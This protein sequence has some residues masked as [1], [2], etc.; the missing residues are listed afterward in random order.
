MT[1]AFCLPSSSSQCSSPTNEDLDP[2]ANGPTTIAVIWPSPEWAY[3]SPQSVSWVAF[4]PEEQLCLEKDN[5]TGNTQRVMVIDGVPCA[6]YASQK[7]L[8]HPQH[9]VLPI[10]RQEKGHERGSLPLVAWATRNPILQ[11]WEYF[12]A[13]VS[14]QVEEVFQ[15][16]ESEVNVAVLNQLWFTI[17]FNHMV[18][19]NEQSQFREVR[20]FEMQPVWEFFDSRKPGWLSFSKKMTDILEDRCTKGVAELELVIQ[21]QKMVVDFKRMRCRQSNGEYLA[22]RHTTIEAEWE[23]E[24]ADHKPM[25]APSPADLQHHTVQLQKTKMRLAPKILDFSSGLADQPL[26]PLLPSPSNAA[27]EN[28]AVPFNVFGRRSSMEAHMSFNRSAL[29]SKRRADRSRSE[30]YPRQGSGSGSS[31]SNWVKPE[32]LLRPPRDNHSPV[33]DVLLHDLGVRR[34]MSA[35]ESH[36]DDSFRLK[37]RN[38]RGRLLQP[39]SS[40]PLSPSSPTAEP[41]GLSPASD[42]SSKPRGIKSNSVPSSL[43][44]DSGR[45]RTTAAS[46]DRHSPRSWSQPPEVSLAPSNNRLRAPAT[47]S[48][49]RQRSLPDGKSTVG[50]VRR[51]P[52]SSLGEDSP[53]SQA[54]S[55]VGPR[56]RVDN[57]NPGYAPG[58]GDVRI[59]KERLRFRENARPRVDDLNL[60]YEPGGGRVRIFSEKLDFRRRA[61]ARVDDDNLDHEPGGGL[62]RIVSEKVDFRRRAKPR[63]DDNNLQHEPGGGDIQ[64]L[65]D[66][67]DFRRKAKPKVDTRSY[68]YSSN[69]LSSTNSVTG[70]RSSRDLYSPGYKFGTKTESTVRKAPSSPT[71][72]KGRTSNG[73]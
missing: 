72:P 57:R 2:M 39:V 6:I 60:Y 8:H 25:Q 61:R 11:A 66:R 30:N 54:F 10:R 27:H 13:T 63:V 17:D 32:A 12:P 71:R 3:F 44:L 42:T 28:G 18:Q 4:V 21:G 22:M 68:L 58:G 50:I 24:D 47:K 62:V 23:T 31:P 49:P 37:Q 33:P 41:L 40:P 48:R 19:V 7:V 29:G 45:G 26:D 64:I 52:S 56:A 38:S 65:N 16:G 67:V 43:Q 14:A 5:L 35:E 15:N 59:W 34:R 9:G 36:L 73:R 70:Q 1:N 46:R 20:R 53:Q 69:A 55:D 51:A